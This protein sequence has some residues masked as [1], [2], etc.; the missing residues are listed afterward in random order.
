MEE[1]VDR[2]CQLAGQL[3]M[4]GVPLFIFH[5]GGEPVAAKAFRQLARITHGAYCAF[6]SNSARQLRD[7]LSAVAVYAAGGTQALEDFHRRKGV[8]ILQLMHN[9]KT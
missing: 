1:N 8:T 7:L 9:D 3:A 6:D 2:L 5:E 4:L